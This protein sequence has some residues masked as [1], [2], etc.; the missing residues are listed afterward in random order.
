[1]RYAA[2]A[3]AIALSGVLLAVSS[4]ESEIIKWRA[5]RVKALTADDG[6]LTLAGL[7]WLH[8]GANRFGSD[9]ANEI[10]L[11]AGPPHA[12]ELEF[13]KGLVTYQGK[14]LKPDSGDPIKVGRISLF[15][16]KRSDRYGVRVKD[17]ETPERKNFHGFEYFPISDE[18]RIEAK[19]VAEPKNIPILNVIGQTEQSP[20]PGYAS[21]RLHGQDLRLY[22]ILETMD[23]KEL[24]YIFRDQTSG[25]ETYGAGRFFYSDMPLNGK[26]VID[27]NKAYNPPCAFTAYATCPLPPRENRLPVRV[28][29]GEKK[30]GEH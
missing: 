17:P 30:Y 16:I 13:H 9:G 27:F 29:A 8:E 19:W 12:G 22:P 24:F 14:E 26:I 21:F 2:F 6:W 18:Y 23:A 1:M 3:G 25:N 10:T 15:V 4:H 28:E 7:F 11:L 5:D 20:N